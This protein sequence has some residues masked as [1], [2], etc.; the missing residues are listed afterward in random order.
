M[1]FQFIFLAIPKSTIHNEPSDNIVEKTRSL[2][3]YTDTQLSNPLV[4]STVDDFIPDDNDY[5]TFLVDD[6]TTD[7]QQEQHISIDTFTQ[8][9]ITKLSITDELV[10]SLNIS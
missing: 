1:F 6:N 4:K 5:E 2:D 10:F 3:D 9:S 8:S 7:Q